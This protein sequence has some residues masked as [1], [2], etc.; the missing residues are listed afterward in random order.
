M[1]TVI[2]V[3]IA[4]VAAVAGY[5]IGLLRSH[6][7]AA[8]EREKTR[9]ELEQARADTAAANA[10]LDAERRHTAEVQRAQAETQRAQTEAL[11][12]EFRHMAGE[13]VRQG[14]E[15]L[16]TTNQ[17]ALGSLLKPLGD[18]LETFREQYLKGTAD[19]NRYIRDL[20]QHAEAVGSEADKLA[21]ALKGNSKLQGNWG[22]VVLQNLLEAAGL[23]AGRDFEVQA[24]TTD[25][26]GRT[27]IPD[28]VVKLPQDRAIVIDSKVS[29]TAYTD[30]VAAL[31]DSDAAA[32]SAS[33]KSHVDSVV[34]H[35]KEL[36]EKHYDRVVKNH[37]GY[38]LMFI[39]SE[40]AYVAAVSADPQ[41]PV[42]AYKRQVILINP[43]NLLMALQLAHNLWQ[44]ELQSRS[45]K[46]IYD[47]A[48]KLYKKFT[49]FAEN[50]LKVG[51]T[52]R[53]AGAAYD[54]AEKQLTTGRNNVVSQLENWRK[55]GLTPTSRLPKALLPDDDDD[56]AAANDDTATDNGPASLA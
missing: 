30:Y 35:V 15:T 23:E 28:V 47:S 37:I 16:R 26:E 17:Q 4:V 33:L 31:A 40:A 5:A 51:N 54:R 52:I 18:N 38:V 39:P 29:L 49:A 53:Q 34:R 56:T 11:R 25:S 36:S 48:E 43:T 55:K 22:E 1:N 46:E 10:R 12:N 44:S 27:L 21:R 24:R 42:M 13:M 7:A 2:I 45:V 6:S 19:M 20:M 41:L 32:A 9:A 50:F 3:L 14:G 8:A